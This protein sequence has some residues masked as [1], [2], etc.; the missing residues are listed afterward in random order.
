[1]KAIGKRKVLIAALAALAVGGG[2]AALAATQ[3][4]SPTARSDAIVSD[5]ATQLG[6]EPEALSNA[7]KKAAEKQVDADV[8]AGRL[9]K[10]QGDRLKAAIEA[11]NVPLA[12]FGPALA[13]GHFGRALVVALDA[14][15]TYLGV[16]KAELRQELRSGKSL[17]QIATAHGRSVDGLVSALVDAAKKQLDAAA[18]AG[19]I[20]PERRQA[21][22]ANLEQRITELVNAEPPALPERWRADRGFGLGAFGLRRFG[23]AVLPPPAPV[24][25][26]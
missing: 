1:V 17:A 24:A 11:G 23:G 8:A 21:I 16:T 4:D 26:A 7:L 20:T 18:A 13:H 14:A 3:L 22:E 6:I 10:E 19:G 25:R 9:T 15:A 5:A 12:G 2:G